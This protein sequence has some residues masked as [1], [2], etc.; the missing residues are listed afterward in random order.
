M[1]KTFNITGTIIACFIQ[2]LF[3]PLL[4]TSFAIHRFHVLELKLC[5]MAQVF[6][7]NRNH[8]LPFSRHFPFFTYKID[9]LT[10]I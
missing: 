9:A 2:L 4:I 3:T 5:Y 1:S 8:H 10:Y 6:N 7:P